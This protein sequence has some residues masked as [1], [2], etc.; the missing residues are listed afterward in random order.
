MDI[1]D[2]Y[3]V[4]SDKYNR[5]IVLL[6][7]KGCYW[8]KCTF[9][10][11]FDDKGTIEECVKVNEEVLKKVTGEYKTLEV[12]NSGSFQE[13]DFTTKQM[14][15][16][17]CVQ[18]NIKELTFESHYKY[19]D[20]IKDIKNEFRQIGVN[21]F[22]KTGIETFDLTIRNSFN[23]D[24]DDVTPIELSNYFDDICLLHGI[25]GQTNDMIEEDIKIGLKYF[26]RICV[27]I[28]NEN[29][30]KTKRD[31]QLVQEFLNT[32]YKKYKDFENIDILI[33]NTDFG[34]GE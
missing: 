4:I 14:I 11:Y 13:L 5:E 28:F 26:R 16:D 27:N 20:T 32:T 7:G 34:V 29:T 17:I 12:V 1:E 23:K 15:K 25:V 22:V 24:I 31:N 8:C 3:S 6:K 21:V 30:T 2:R 18:K 19:K 33:N 9:C 10:D